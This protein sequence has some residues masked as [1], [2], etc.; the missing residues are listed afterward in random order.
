METLKDEGEACMSDDICKTGLCDGLPS[1]C[2]RK[3]STGCLAEE[4]CTQLTPGRFS[5]QPDQRRLCQSCQV[6]S[7]CPYPA[8]KCLVVNGEQ[9][10]G[11]DC[12]FDQSCPSGYV[13][14]NGRGSGCGP[15]RDFV[16]WL[17][18]QKAL[19]YNFFALNSASTPGVGQPG[20]WDG[21]Q[22]NPNTL[23]DYKFTIDIRQGQYG[24]V[25]GSSTMTVSVV[26]APGALALLGAAGLVG[27]RRRKA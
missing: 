6:D 17:D 16:K 25:V 1:V 22:F 9:V 23:G 20:L 8:D 3:C 19:G 26:P 15:S 27:G 14:V 12:A 13:C 10:C 24:S 21:L 4:V 7:D 11:R 2:V 5:C 18:E